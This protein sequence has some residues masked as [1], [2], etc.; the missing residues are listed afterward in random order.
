MREMASDAALLE[1]EFGLSPRRRSAATKA[2]RK[3]RV[4]RASDEFIQPRSA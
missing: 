4:A 1:A 3:T 2:E